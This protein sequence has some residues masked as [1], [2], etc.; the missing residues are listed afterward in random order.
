MIHIRMGS[1]KFFGIC[2][3]DK[4]MDS[5]CYPNAFILDAPQ[6]LPVYFGSKTTA[7]KQKR[8]KYIPL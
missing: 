4:V 1:A 7:L 2:K 6:L 8:C 5:K 3:V